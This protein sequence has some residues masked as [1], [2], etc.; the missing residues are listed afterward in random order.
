MN[1][2]NKPNR[3]FLCE[4]LALKIIM[5]CRTVAARKFREKLGFISHDMIN[6]K[7]QTVLGTIKDAFEGENMQTQYNVL[8]CIIDLYFHGYKFAIEVDKYGHKIE[9]LTMKYKDKIQ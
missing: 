1:E 8:G 9:I 2:K 7:G 6:T 4:D 5:D 3:M